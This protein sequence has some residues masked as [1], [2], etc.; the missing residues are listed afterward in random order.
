V[1]AGKYRVERV[2]GAGGMGVVVAAHHIQLETKV[3]LKFLLPALLADRDAVGRFAREAKAAAK[4][5]SDHVARVLDVGELENGAPY[6]VM[7][8]LEGIDLSKWLELH[9]R[10]PVADAV[11]F[12]L[13]A[14][15]AV[16]EAHR[17]GIVHRDLKP[18]NLFCIRRSDGGLFIKVLDF[19]ISKLAVGVD[20]GTGLSMTRT[21][22]TMGSPLYMSPEQM[23]SAKTV[24]TQTDIWAL[25][26]VLHE[27]LAG[28]PPFTGDTLPELAIK[29]AIQ[30]PPPL[31]SLRPDAPVGLE[32]VILR[33]LEKDCARRYRHVG[34]LALG[35][36][37]FAPER[38][39][40]EVQRILGIVGV[41][42]HSIQA[43]APTLA[44]P[45]LSVAFPASSP[46]SGRASSPPVVA[47]VAETAAAPGTMSP[48]GRST[49][50]K[51]DGRSAGRMPLVLGAIA[52]VAAV[53]GV[54]AAALLHRSTSTDMTGTQGASPQASPLSA[55]PQA[56]AA[57]VPLPPAAPMPVETLRPEPAAP[58]VD[59]TASPVDHP[60]H[61]HP[62]PSPAPHTATSAAPAAPSA[63]APQAPTAAPVAPAPNTGPAHGSAASS[64]N[65]TPPYYY[66]A[67][68]NRV[69]KKECVE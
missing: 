7:E 23:Q 63:A 47:P 55:S 3:A 9:G 26:V 14:S 34:E 62:G 59:H 53:V 54:G 25:G 10:L 1:L 27:L 33:C 5:A 21:T 60:P 65:C 13:Q 45:S 36:A 52:V 66:D 49:S 69:F 19:G 57:P 16:A 4:I 15:V 67:N 68:G 40:A 31:R 41:S 30:P 29:V 32:A 46:P 11:D 51:G 42:G 28:T 6:M 58:A 61:H 56:P 64:V 43:Q 22:A 38:A 44:A 12:V 50:G 18:A 39:R 35:L 24:G 17:L 8:F 48:F 2:L 20:G 37:E